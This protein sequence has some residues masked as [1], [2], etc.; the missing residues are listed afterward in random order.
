MYAC[1]KTRIKNAAA[2][3]AIATIAAIATNGISRSA[4]SANPSGV[5]TNRAR[6]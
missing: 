4:I 1:S 2:A 5:V 6:G 3:A